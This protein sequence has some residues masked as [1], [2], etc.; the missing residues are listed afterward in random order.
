MGLRKTTQT[1][2]ISQQDDSS[3]LLPIGDAQ[4]ELFPDTREKET[5]VVKVLPLDK[6]IDIQKI[7]Q[8]SLVKIDVQGYEL[9]TLKGCSTALS[10]I[11]YIYVECSFK[12][13]YLGQALAH[14]IIKIPR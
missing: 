6:V 3:S 10:R 8:P 13:L 11:S 12:E 9:E 7:S 14:E 4:V 1:I 5:R 2:H